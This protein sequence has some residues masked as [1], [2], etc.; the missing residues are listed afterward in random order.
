MRKIKT[1]QLANLV[2][3]KSVSYDEFMDLCLTT[4]NKQ[5][6]VQQKYDG[7]WCAVT[8]DG[9][10]TKNGLLRNT[11]IRSAPGIIYIGEYLFG[12]QWAERQPRYKQVAV[13][14]CNDVSGFTFGIIPEKI[15]IINDFTPAYTV[16]YI[17]DVLLDFEGL[18]LK[19]VVTGEF[20]RYKRAFT[21]DYVIL[22]CIPSTAKTLKGWA[23][24]TVELGLYIDG[25]LTP[26]GTAGGFDHATQS[27]MHLNPKRFVGRVAE[28]EGKAVFKSGKLR[29]PAFSRWRE[30]KTPKQC[31]LKQFEGL[32]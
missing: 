18:V 1:G 5:Y 21:G 12:T 22:R 10:Y 32:I 11:E 2:D 27:V 28:F 4:V 17:K 30:D 25:Q 9:I 24:S 29:H 8:P 16:K 19:D 15:F 31:T 3:Y 13:Y 14:A 20:R 7:W 26:V 23:S 6:V